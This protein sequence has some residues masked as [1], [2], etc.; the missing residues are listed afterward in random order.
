MDHNVLMLENIEH[1]QKGF[2][3]PVLIELTNLVYQKY[4][5]SG[6]GMSKTTICQALNANKF[7]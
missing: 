2:L 7:H 3:E 4:A 5:D 6:N 1:K